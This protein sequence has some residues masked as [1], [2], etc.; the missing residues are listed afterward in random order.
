MRQIQ[1]ETGESLVIFFK[2]L[3]KLYL[4]FLFIYTLTYCI[5]EVIKSRLSWVLNE[6]IV[7]L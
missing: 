7:D 3:I 5:K 4:S 2:T 6:K 1:P